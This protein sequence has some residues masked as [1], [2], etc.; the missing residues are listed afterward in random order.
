M[1]R[2]ASPANAIFCELAYDS[3]RLSHDKEGDAP[4]KLFE[5]NI[6]RVK[7]F[8]S[9]I[10]AISLKRKSMIPGILASFG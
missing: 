2:F 9:N 8:V 3:K 10:L 5:C 1:S 7:V 4:A 6:L